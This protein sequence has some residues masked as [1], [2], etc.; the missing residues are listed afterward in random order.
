MPSNYRTHKILVALLLVQ[1]VLFSVLNMEGPSMQADAKQDLLMQLDDVDKITI[2]GERGSVVLRKQREG[3]IL[4]GSYFPADQGN[5]EALLI[6]LGAMKHGLP[7]TTTKEAVERFKV[8]EDHFER[9]IVLSQDNADVATLYL[10]T[11]PG[12]RRIH[13][14]KAGSDAVYAV[15]FGLYDASEDRN[16]WIDKQLLRLDA[17][18]ITALHVDGVTYTRRAWESNGTIERI[19][20][21]ADRPGT[22]DAQKLS[23][24]GEKIAALHI[25][26]MTDLTEISAPL[27][28]VG[29]DLNDSRSITYTF[30][31][32]DDNATTAYYFKSSARAEVFTLPAAE[33]EAIVALARGVLPTPGQT[34]TYVDGDLP[35]SH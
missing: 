22:P 27:L 7:V 35:Q 13:L 18:A 11:S 15:T 20:W 12:A 6:K 2:T 21:E 1:L 16:A 30:G 8:A 24:L 3:W 31:K 23:A 5:V 26:T 17:E 10:G 25:A 29:A 33:A 32:P 19:H 4:G 9:R 14:R 34:P 28:R